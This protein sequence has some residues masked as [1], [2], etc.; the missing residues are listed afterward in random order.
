M[1]LDGIM[2]LQILGFIIEIGATTAGVITIIGVIITT[3]IEMLVMQ[4]E[5]SITLIEETLM[6]TQDLLLL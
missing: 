1:V 6:K 5:T 2:A 3:E 4:E